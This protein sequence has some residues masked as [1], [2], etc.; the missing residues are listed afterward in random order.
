M[1]EELIQLKENVFNLLWETSD[2][3]TA[4]QAALKLVGTHLG[5]DS[6]YLAELTTGTDPA[7]SETLFSWESTAAAAENTSLKLEALKE[8][9]NCDEARSG[10]ADAARTVDASLADDTNPIMDRPA[11]DDA[12]GAGSRE[13]VFWCTDNSPQC[14]ADALKHCGTRS[15]LLRPIVKQGVLSAYFGVDD[16]RTRRTDWELDQDVQD[17]INSI[18]KVIGVFLL[19]ERY[20]K[21]SEEIQQHLE[22]SL[23]AS[24]QRADTAYELLDSISAGVIIV[25]IYPDGSARPQYGNLG[26]YRILRIPRT[27]ENA[28]VPD[29]NAAALEGEYFDDFFAN[30]P[31]PDYSR[32]RAEYKT[33][34]FQDHFSVRKYRLLRGDGTYAWVSADLSLRETAPAYRTYYVTYTDVSEEHSLQEGLLEMLEKEK[35][36]TFKLEKASQ[37][38]SDF[39][40]R[41]SHDI[42]TPMNA[43][44]GMTAIAGSHINNPSRVLDCLEKI[45]V[46]SKLLLSIINEVL[47]MS[48]VESGRLVLA[49][50]EVD[51]AEL[52]QG[53]VTMV[54]PQIESKRLKFEARLNDVA[55]EAVISDIQRLQQVLIN[56]LSNAVKYTPEGGRILLEIYEE[57][58]NYAEYACYKFVV[59]DT[60]IG[61]TSEFLTRIFEPFER[62]EDERMDPVQGTGLGLSICR[63]IAEMMGGQIE[64]ESEWGK[65]S[66]FTAVLYLRIQQE[67]VDD[68][69]LAGLPILVV[70]NDE[71]VCSVTCGRLKELGMAAEWVSEGRAAV[72]KVVRAHQAGRDYFAVIVDLKMPG[73]DGMQT[74]RLIREKVGCEL[75][76][77]MISAYDLSEQMDRAQE[78]GANGF[79][80]KPLFRSRLV[81]K[82]KEFL[83]GETYGALSMKAPVKRLPPDQRLLLVEDNELN[84]EIAVELI[85]EAGIRVDTAENGKLA[86]EMVEESPEGY[87]QM[88]FMDMQM[89]VMDGC[90]AAAAI[91]AL[92]REDTKTMPIVAMTANAFADDRQRTREAGMNEHMAKPIDLEQLN[93]ILHR[94]LN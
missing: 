52:V 82:L 3:D 12:A 16:S 64:A 29:R 81:Y 83:E 84:R 48:K 63:T 1:K 26:M 5:A 58:S 66:R 39:L 2:F 11:A 33:G 28:V 53:V 43:I 25:D 44:M 86:V 30:I 9:M 35:E 57:P 88:I 89:P 13:T 21:R 8:L 42:R 56:L 6:A 14:V 65:G 72:E 37:A 34:F 7:A 78:A 54:Q 70:D 15:V 60:G 71:I 31:E 46:S 80:T 38:K 40:S 90:A 22:E 75:P 69:G 67:P 76:I 24:E 94:F 23:Q 49:E 87:Y 62:A 55:H 51:L 61:M 20:T 74:T 91:R 27:A 92:D 85:G 10:T 19:K 47:D 17:T 41:M 36:I 4:V 68:G 73:L 59:S 32:V 93:V 79:I 18:A 45:S 77:I 50:E